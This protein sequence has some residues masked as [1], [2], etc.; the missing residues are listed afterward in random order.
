MKILCFLCVELWSIQK[1]RLPSQ[2][3]GYFSEL[4][5]SIYCVSVSY[6]SV[7]ML[8]YSALYTFKFQ[9]ISFFS[10]NV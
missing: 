8:E 6:M 2:L 9:R 4:L 1:D 7:G 10:D 5:A 3:T